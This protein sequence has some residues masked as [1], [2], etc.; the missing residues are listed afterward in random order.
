LGGKIPAFHSSR[1]ERFQ[2]GGQRDTVIPI[3][4]KVEQHVKQEI[5]EEEDI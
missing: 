2:L 5:K 3:G 1:L 4:F